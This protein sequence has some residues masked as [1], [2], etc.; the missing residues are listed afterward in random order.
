MYT[1]VL[2][3]IKNINHLW[4]FEPNFDNKNNDKNPF[5]VLI[6]NIIFLIVFKLI[7]SYRTKYYNIALNNTSGCD[8]NGSLI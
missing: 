1:I 2:I 8:H 3:T 5:F 4:K 6:I 7:N